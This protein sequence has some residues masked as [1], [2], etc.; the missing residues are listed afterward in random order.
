MWVCG[1]ATGERREEVWSELHK[2]KTC[3]EVT[4]KREKINSN[5]ELT[6]QFVCVFRQNGW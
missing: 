3:G 5:R 4:G 2:I 6:R 1:A